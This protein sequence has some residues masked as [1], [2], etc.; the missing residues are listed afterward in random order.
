ML[1]CETAIGRAVP[2]CAPRVTYPATRILIVDDDAL[3]R[4][5][6]SRAL[7]RFG[8]ESIE[9]GDGREALQIVESSGPVLLLLDYEMPE[10]T[11]AQVCELVR[12]HHDPKINTLPVL[13][14]T[15][16]AGEEHEVESLRAGAD[17][18]VTKPV[19]LPILKARIDTQLRLHDLRAQLQRQFTELEEWQR[20]HEA[21]LEA[22]CLTQ[23]ALLPQRPPPIHGWEIA[24]HFQPLIQVGGDIF[25]WLRLSDGSWLVWI[26]DA[27]GHGVSAALHTTLIK[28]LFRHAATEA[29]SPSAI[30]ATVNAEL[31]SIFKG[32]SIMTAAC[33]VL[34]AGNDR[35]FFA[36]GGHPPLFLVR[37]HGGVKSLPSL[38]PPLGITAELTCE[39]QCAAAHPGDTLLLYTDGLY[40]LSGTERHLMP[41]ELPAAFPRQAPSARQF[42]DQ[43]IETLIAPAQGRALPDDLA[44]IALRRV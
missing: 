2:D 42:L 17:D 7:E 5:L 34:R 16:H 12:Q 15:A 44:A 19:S 22:A 23:Q 39:D 10:F 35:L 6:L 26:A 43:T 38:S 37:A 1:Y 33:L 13:L 11:G 36:G 29:C 32:A 8:Y 14:L 31:F 41:S 9:C 20:R 4:Q 30:L 28:L 24:A 40:S 25:D 3:S 18:F 21:D 27:T